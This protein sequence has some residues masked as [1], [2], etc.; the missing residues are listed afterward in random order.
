MAGFI[1]EEQVRR[2]KERSD[3]VE[4][5]GQYAQLHKAGA[6]FR[7]CCVFHAERTPSMY[8]RPAEQTYHCF[9]CGVHGDVIRL[10]MEKERLE[11]T[12]AVELLAR[13]AGITLEY[14]AR[15]SAKRS[16]RDR[17]M[18]LLEFATAFYERQ[19]WETSRAADARAYL[20]SRRLSEA[21]CRRFRLG[22]AP[23]SG[24]LVEEARRKGFDPALLREADLA[25]ERDGRTGDRFFERVTFPIHDRFGHP[26]AF[27]ARLLPEA[28][29]A[30]KAAGRGVG[31]YVNSTDTPLY[32]KSSV[33][34]N[35]HR[36]RL[37][38]RERRR[39]I[40]MEGPTDVMAADQAGYGECVAVLGTAL[41]PD[42]SRQLGN[43]V[44]GE[45]RL[46]LLLDGDAAGQANGL[47]GVRTCM[48][49]GVPVQVAL[50]P[51]ELDPAELLAE[52][53]AG[54]AGGQDPERS[55]SEARQLF[56]TVLG[57]S[58]PDL[59]HLL[60]T[61]APRPYDLDHQRR[62]AV[63]DEI[64]AA[65]RTVPDPALQS[66]HLRDC[67]DWF[68]ISRQS[69]D[70]RM[71]AAQR[72]AS[73]AASAEAAAGGAAVALE[74]PLPPEEDSIL[75]ILVQRPDLRAHAADDLA[76]EPGAFPGRW[77]A[78]AYALLQET[79]DTNLL[80]A[81]PEIRE[82]A[83]V[84]AAAYRWVQTV[85][86]ERTPVA[87]GDARACLEEHAGQLVLK[88]LE[89]QELRLARSMSEAGADPTAMI[90]LMSERLQLQ[91]RIKDLRGQSGGTA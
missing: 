23:G 66:L 30:A 54:A 29:R 34:F 38:E 5:M 68:G 67:A 8:V 32:H 65:V 57:E 74:A 53:A 41:T 18:P 64:L 35:L 36:A 62:L 42:H 7:A 83:V 10:V 45:G 16:Q 52:G 11:F 90:R 1:G 20:A 12:E 25:V 14:D 91:R 26:V 60:R 82:D 77:Q 48:S 4:I 13:R 85:L 86:A 17:L 75:H 78:V 59:Q 21:T 79:T 51:Q 87:I 19:L 88:Q 49:V 46:L 61:L 3:L 63:L 40:I 50:L 2:V 73:A 27:S 6:H 58:R 37:A 22:W 15:D 80:L 89:D 56:E 70:A 81:L 39:I 55:L 43:L 84:R 31:K 71:N 69:I 47:K 33:V 76:L 24:L 28:E 72:P 44:G 9:G